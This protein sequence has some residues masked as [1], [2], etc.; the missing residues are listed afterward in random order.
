M[1]T[2]LLRL[3]VKQLRCIAV[4]KFQFDELFRSNDTERVRTV[5]KTTVLGTHCQ[6]PLAAKFQFIEL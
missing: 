2:A 3:S 5:T 4:S 6:R 1:L